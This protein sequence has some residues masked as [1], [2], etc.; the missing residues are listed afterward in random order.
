M[1]TS[2]HRFGTPAYA[3][4]GHNVLYINLRLG[5]HFA[6]NRQTRKHRTSESSTG[7]FLFYDEKCRQRAVAW[8]VSTLDQFV[9]PRDTSGWVESFTAVIIGSV[10]TELPPPQRPHRSR[11]WC[12]SAETLVAFVL[13]LQHGQRQRMRDNCCAPS[14]AIEALERH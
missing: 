1:L 3:D 9:Q 4:A 6:P 8:T 10:G 14:L 12:E 5:G 2:S 11:E 13:L 7:S